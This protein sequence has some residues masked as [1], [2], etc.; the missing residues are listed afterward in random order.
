MQEQTP[1]FGRW[2]AGYQEPALPS[3]PPGYRGASSG[4]GRGGGGREG[5]GPS[6][7]PNSSPE[8]V[9]FTWSYNKFLQNVKHKYKGYKVWQFQEET[10]EEKI[11]KLTQQLRDAKLQLA[12]SKQR[13]KEH[14]KKVEVLEEREVDR[15]GVKMREYMREKRGERRRRRGR[16]GVRRVWRR[17]ARRWRWS[18]SAGRGTSLEVNPKDWQ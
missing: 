11:A 3:Q 6:P 9:I 13:E 14:E 15:R 10:A 16:R 8:T 2:K 18:G 1:Y 17:E 12:E 4:A 7:H 5:G